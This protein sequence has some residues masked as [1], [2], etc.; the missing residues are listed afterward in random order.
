MNLI[1]QDQLIQKGIIVLVLL[2]RVVIALVLHLQLDKV[3]VETVTEG[4]KVEGIN[5]DQHSR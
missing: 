2:H 3:A 5:V 4:I 1:P